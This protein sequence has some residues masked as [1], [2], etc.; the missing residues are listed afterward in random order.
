MD[1]NESSG[2]K[3][4]GAGIDTTFISPYTYVLLPREKNAALCIK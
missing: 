1:N 2:Q 3:G 4:E